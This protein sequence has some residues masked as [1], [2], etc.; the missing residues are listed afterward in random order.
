MEAREEY[1]GGEEDSDKHAAEVA[2]EE[3]REAL[4]DAIGRKKLSGR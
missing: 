2:K 1:G 4:G 3:K